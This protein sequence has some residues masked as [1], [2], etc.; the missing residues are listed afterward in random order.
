MALFARRAVIPPEYIFHYTNIH[1]AI[2]ILEQR[3]LRLGSPKNANDPYDCMD[4]LWQT[5]TPEF[6]QKLRDNYLRDLTGPIQWR[7]VPAAYRKSL[8]ESR[9]RLS[10]LP[11]SKRTSEVNNIVDQLVA[12]HASGKDDSDFRYLRHRLRVCSFSEVP[13]NMLMWAHYAQKQA[14]CVLE[15]R[16]SVLEQHWK[17]PLCKV[18]YVESPPCFVP[19]PTVYLDRLRMDGGRPPLSTPDVESWTCSKAMC[20]EYER[21]WRFAWLDPRG[22]IEDHAFVAFPA[23]AIKSI[24]LGVG[25]AAE[26]AQ[27][28][29]E[30]LRG[31]YPGCDTLQMGLSNG[32][33]GFSCQSINASNAVAQVAGSS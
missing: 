17:R 12:D 5:R 8:G 9:A 29:V 20:W 15:F 7:K 23:S 3:K 11:P 14:G 27:H 33:F 22:T 32:A 2:K 25:V 30:L 4:T 19:D 18:N 28:A 26:A 24:R 16:T 10:A 6:V 13:D 21:E 31:R 1:A